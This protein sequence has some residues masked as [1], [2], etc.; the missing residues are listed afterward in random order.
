M[1]G[2]SEQGAS[3]V[4]NHTGGTAMPD[5]EIDAYLRDLDAACEAVRASAGEAK[6]SVQPRYN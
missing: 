1:G 6:E 2:G 4:R 5:A 3:A